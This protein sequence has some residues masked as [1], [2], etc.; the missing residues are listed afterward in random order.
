MNP[1]NATAK[2]LSVLFAADSGPEVGGGHLMRCLSLAQALAGRGATCAFMA[3]RDAAGVLDAFAGKAIGRLK[4][5]QGRLPGFAYESASQTD[6]W[7]AD[8]VVIDHY[9]ISAGLEQR[10]RRAGRR[11]VVID[12]LADREHDCDLLIDPGLGRRDA[13]YRD[14][15]PAAARVLAGPDYA[16]LRSEYAQARP[17][18]LSRRVPGAAPTRLLVAL[19]LTDLRGITGRVLN[20]VLPQLGDLE[21]DVVVGARAPS[22]TWLKHLTETDGRLRLHVQSNEMSR[23]MT[24]AD[25]AIGAGGSSTWERACLGLPSISLIL[26]E[27][28]RQMAQGLDS[29]GAVLAVDAVGEGLPERLLAAFQRLTTDAQLRTRL[30]DASAAL[31]DGLGA[32]RCADA[33]VELAGSV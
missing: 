16:L 25:I 24:L 4:A 5:S 32:N 8:V 30:A 13:D 18:A 3:P 26:A 29:D 20:I 21:V 28:Q 19:G 17:E 22:L 7:G 31:C 6:Q 23:L 9:G 11:I 12:D 15:V 14:L 33:I 10:F 2:P 27:N 1:A